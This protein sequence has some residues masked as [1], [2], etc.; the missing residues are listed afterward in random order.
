MFRSLQQART[1]FRSETNVLRGRWT[2]D[3]DRKIL[4]RK[5]YLTNMDHCGCCGVIQDIA[6]HETKEDKLE[7]GIHSDLMKYYVM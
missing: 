1:F 3:Y 5:V 4:D 7:F 6:V 2:L